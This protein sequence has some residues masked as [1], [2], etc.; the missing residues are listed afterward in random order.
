MNKY[1]TYS[2]L[3]K[4]LSLDDFPSNRESIAN[5]LMSAEIAWERFVALADNHLILQALYPKIKDH[6]LEES[7]PEEVTEHLKYIFELTSQRNLT[8]I[9]QTE[10]LTTVLRK[11]GIAPL[12][13]KGVG[14]I[15]DG[16]YKNPGERI[17]HDIDILV[18]E[19]KFEHAAEILIKD[20]YRSNYTYKPELKEK[21]RHYPIL[22]KEGE[23]VYVELHRM[24]VGSRYTRY[25]NTEMVFASAK[26]PLAYPDCLVMSDEHKIIHNF[27][28]AQVDHLGRIYA[29]EFM[30]NLYDLHLLSNRKNP[31]VVLAEFGHFRRASSG[32]LD[33]TYA[34][35]GKKPG[36]RKLPAVFLHSFQYRYYLNL[37]YRFVGVTSLLFIR[38][39]LGYI[40]KPLK[41]IT[42]KEMR[43]KILSDLGSKKWYL[44]Q[45][46][47]YRRLFGIQG[48]KA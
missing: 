26:P 48:K 25:F 45:I 36:E 46:K 44:K 12:Y 13:M 21:N 43:D 9:S 38:V 20:G 18:P 7:L 2:L 14:N 16:L 31:D 34:T 1:Q 42:D 39:F 41:A 19:E 22:F 6:K 30:R 33:I 28:H 11:E 10:K 8:V 5:E 32:Y 24:P 29:R 3:G 40:G 4:I 35:F 15:L 27:M 17:L 23:P 37:R 47:F